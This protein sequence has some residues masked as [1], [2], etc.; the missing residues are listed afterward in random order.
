[1]ADVPPKAATP[2]KFTSLGVRALTGLSL[3]AICG[4]PIYFGGWLFAGL[5]AL[6]GVRIL[7]EWVRMSVPAFTVLDVLIPAAVLFAALY[8][9]GVMQWKFAILSALAG[10]VACGLLTLK[11]GRMLW[12][13]F[14]VLY[15]VLPAIAAVY[16]RGFGAGFADDGFAK[17][18]LIV[19]AVIGADS[20]AYL[21]GSMIKGPKLAPRISPNKTWSGFLSGLILGAAGCALVAFWLGL[22]AKIAFLFAVPVVLLSVA[23]DLFE[24]AIKRSL[25]VKDA[26]GL[27]PGHG[28]LLDR[29]DSLLFAFLFC[30]AMLYVQPQLWGMLAG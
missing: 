23:G 4:L 21:G 17:M 9:A 24:S 10:S 27:L 28:G 19:A 2:A 15:V 14:G 20:F 5:V 22:D 3:L 6:A 1:M 7:Y 13:G 12:A 18:A 26:G 11:R 16:L 8:F 30:A 29:A 25:Q